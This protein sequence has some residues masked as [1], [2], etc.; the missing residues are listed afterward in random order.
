MRASSFI[1]S[2]WTNLVCTKEGKATYITLFVSRQSPYIRTQKSQACVLFSV[3]TLPVLT[4]S[5]PFDKEVVPN[6]MTKMCLYDL[7]MSSNA[8]PSILMRNHNICQ[9]STHIMVLRLVNLY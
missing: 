6:I 1:I 5:R 9:R 2:Y 7:H 8:Q 3:G 4:M